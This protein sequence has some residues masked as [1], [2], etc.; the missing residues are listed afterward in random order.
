MIEKDTV[1]LLRECDAG[2][3]MGIDS[4]EDTIGGARSDGLRRVMEESKREHKVIEDEIHA[5]LLSFDDEGKR[6][7]PFLRG[8]SHAMTEMKLAMKG[9][10]STVADLMTDGCNMGIKSLSRYLN[11]YKAASEESKDIA[12]RIIALEERLLLE[13]RGYL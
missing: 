3:K 1:R 2:V 9:G 8:M 5:M 11:E 10:D 4:I 12:K 7:N 6:S 13:V